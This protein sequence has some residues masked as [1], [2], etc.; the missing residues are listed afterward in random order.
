[1]GVGMLVGRAGQR[2]REIIRRGI[3]KRGK[4]I[5]VKRTL[6]MTSWNK[7]KGK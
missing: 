5:S 4:Q 3:V 7:D 6:D 1:M 2:K